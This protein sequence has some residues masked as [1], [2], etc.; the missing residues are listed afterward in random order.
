MKDTLTVLKA[1]YGRVYPHSPIALQN[2]AFSMVGWHNEI[3]CCGRGFSSLL[4]EYESRTFAD[5]EVI[6]DRRDARLKAYLQH[7]YETVPFYRKWFDDVGLHPRD[8]ATLDDLA[9]LPI[10]SKA[11]VQERRHEF[12][13]TGIPRHQRK[14]ISTGGSTGSGLNLATTIEAVQ[15]HWAVWWRYWRWH[16]IDRKT[17]VAI[18][19]TTHAVP[20]RQQAPPFWRY[21]IAGRQIV[22]SCVHMSP[23]N[24][25]CYISELRRRKPLWFHGYPSTIS[26]IASHLIE[27]KTDLGYDVRWITTTGEN[28]LPQQTRLIEEAFG[29]RPKQ[30][31]GMVE[32]IANI[33]ECEKGKLHVDEELAAVEFVPINDTLYRVVGTNLSNPIMPLVRYECNDHVTIEP[34]ESCS[35]GRSGRVVTSIDGRKEDYVVLKNGVHLGRLS[36][37]FN[38][39][40]TV[41][42]AQIRQEIIGEIRIL[43]RRGANYTK[44][45]EK[46]LLAEIQRWIND[47]SIIAIE[48]VDE[49]ERTARGK[50]RMVVSLV[51]AEDAA[52]YKLFSPP[53]L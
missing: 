38:E 5:A 49:I 10:L 52:G 9:A 22:F 43:V 33:S 24:L 36:Q 19:G 20:P 8:V 50:L 27:A 15:E 26:L 7:A 37:I 3:T 17:W 11:S 51:P 44:K 14:Y 2:A 6:R 47:G 1:L 13:S 28:L 21:D 53:V 12:L 31:Y 35:C 46:R 29:V 25:K 40:P 42:E 45:D 32:A 16:G 48:Y 23:E 39:F 4:N 41:L 18:L 34:G 30:H